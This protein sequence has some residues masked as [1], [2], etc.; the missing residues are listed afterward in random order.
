MA[1]GT[2]AAL[3]ALVV[4]ANGCFSFLAGWLLHREVPPWFLLAVSGVVMTF[5]ALGAFSAGVPDFARYVFCLLLAGAGGAVASASFAVAPSLAPSPSQL[6]TINGILVQA[7]SFGQF[8]GPP[9][10][11]AVVSAFGTWES[12][13][14]LMV[15]ASVLLAAL[16]LM[17]RHLTR[18][19]E[20]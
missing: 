15:G 11:A 17:V 13:L 14:W 18:A 6:G 12:A 4:A 9:V 19:A 5:A 7:S 3:T 20:A 16:A 2:A 1:Q 8:L 10:M